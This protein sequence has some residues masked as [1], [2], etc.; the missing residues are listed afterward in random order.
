MEPGNPIPGKFSK[1]STG[2]T[3]IPAPPPPPP[4]QPAWRQGREW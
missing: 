1:P 2:S 4:P 3:A